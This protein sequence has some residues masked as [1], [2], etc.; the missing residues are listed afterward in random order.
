MNLNGKPRVRLR[1]GEEASFNT[2]EITKSRFRNRS[3]SG[4][5]VEE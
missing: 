2:Q 1:T 3:R 5:G 4:S